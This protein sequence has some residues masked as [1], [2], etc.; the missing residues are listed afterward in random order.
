MNGGW[1]LGDLDFQAAPH[2]YFHHGARRELPSVTKLMRENGIGFTGFA[3][4]EALDRGTYTHEASVLIDSDELDWSQVPGEWRG[5]CEGYRRALRDS[6]ARPIAAEGR[7]YHPQFWYAGTF[8]RV[9]MMHGERVGIELKT[10]STTDVSVQAAGYDR[11]WS[12]WFPDKP[13]RR[14]ECWKVNEDG[15]YR[16]IDL[17]VEDGWR[18]FVAC[19]VLSARRAKPMSERI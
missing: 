3:P 4:Q 2:V 1:S 5:Y 15:T 18:S 11:M 19:L 9:A 8:D 7:L 12:Y 10:G 17:D 13:I 6:G 16:R 14:W